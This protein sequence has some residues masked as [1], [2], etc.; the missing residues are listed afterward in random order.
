MDYLTPYRLAAAPVLLVL[1]Y[2][3][4]PYILNSS[5]RKFPGPL[6]A[7]TTRL[8]LAYGSRYGVRSIRVHEQHKAHG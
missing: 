8:W 7:A 1:A 2:V 6:A 4:L 5:L 3:L